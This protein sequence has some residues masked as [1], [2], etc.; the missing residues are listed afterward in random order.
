[1]HQ[2][3]LSVSAIT[4]I[5]TSQL[6]DYF[7]KGEKVGKGRYKATCNFCEKPWNRGEPIVITRSSKLL[8]R[9]SRQS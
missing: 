7:T 6:D 8:M 1:M 9:S 3:F 5:E 2:L 4:F